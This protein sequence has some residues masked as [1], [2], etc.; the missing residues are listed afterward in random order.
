ML[1]DAQ[2]SGGLLLAIPEEEVKSFFKSAGDARSAMWAVGRVRRGSGITVD[3][4]RHNLP[5]T[6]EPDDEDLW[7]SAV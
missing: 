1:F 5:L 3:D 4:T 7:F 6:V 2:T